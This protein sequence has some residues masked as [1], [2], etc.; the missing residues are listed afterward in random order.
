MKKFI[1][2]VLLQFFKSTRNY[3][4]RAFL[5]RIIMKFD[6]KSLSASRKAMKEFY[7]ISIGK[8][9]YGCFK[10]DS[11]IEP[12]TV[13]GSFCSFAPGIVIGGMKHPTH[14]ISTHPFLYNKNAG[15]VQVTND[16]VI[17]EGTKPVVIG[18][19]VW[20]GRNAI[21]LQGV[22][23]GKGSVIASGAVV[24]K[25]VEPYSIVAGVPARTIK[26]RF[27]D[28]QIEDLIKI[29]WANWDDEKI[30]KEINGFYDV[31]SFI[32]NFA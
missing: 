29:D 21:I 9:S 1:V 22:T 17:K 15:Y 26:K 13:I 12:G 28:S 3:Q 20:I 18:D 23:V 14:F 24:T 5:L 16:E 32:K 7:N 27:N 30:K 6:N 10:T 2:T 4:I 19:D 31:D 8:R 11:S 25:S